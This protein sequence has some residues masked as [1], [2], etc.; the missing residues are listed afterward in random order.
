MGQP[1]CHVW[2][3]VR[4][5]GDVQQDPRYLV[6]L[7]KGQD[8]QAFRSGLGRSEVCVVDLE[9]LVETGV[10]HSLQPSDGCFGYVWR[11]SGAVVA[12]ASMRPSGVPGRRVPALCKA[13]IGLWCWGVGD[14]GATGAFSVTR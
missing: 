1:S 10:I 3:L 7:T 8:R 12:D 6:C 13:P 9:D 5:L 4:A 11:G 14:G 2:M